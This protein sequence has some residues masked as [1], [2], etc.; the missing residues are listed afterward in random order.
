MADPV[1]VHQVVSKKHTY[2]VC[3]D[4]ANGKYYLLIDKK[5]YREH[6][7]PFKAD[8]DDVLDKLKELKSAE[9]LKKFGQ[10]AEK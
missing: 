4:E 3:Y 8:F 2:Q 1:V 10:M 5:V 7:T 9:E 6:N